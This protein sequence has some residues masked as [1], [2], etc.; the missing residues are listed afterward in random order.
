MLIKIKSTRD[1]A[2][3]TFIHGI[4]YDLNM[5][6]FATKKAVDSMIENKAAVKLT[7]KQAKKE[8]EAVVSLVTADTADEVALADLAD[9][10]KAVKA[11]NADRDAA[12]NEVKDLTASAETAATDAQAALDAAITERD[13]A[14]QEVEDLKT[15]AVATKPD[16]AK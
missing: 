7:D 16:T 10:E 5:K 12:Q 8:R 11:A 2:V 14:R 6:N 15:S 13:A 4:I 9:A 1:T 3:G